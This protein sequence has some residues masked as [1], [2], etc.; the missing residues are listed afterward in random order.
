MVAKTSPT[1]RRSCCEAGDRMVRGPAPRLRYPSPATYPSAGCRAL[2]SASTSEP[3]GENAGTW[4][5]NDALLGVDGPRL[6]TGDRG[7]ARR[8]QQRECTRRPVL[9]QARLRS[10]EAQGWWLG[11]N[12]LDGALL[13]P[14]SI[15]R[16]VSCTHGAPA[17]P[18]RHG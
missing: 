1:I 10:L 11:Q 14:A 9:V 13:S 2:S 15:A 18:T 7:H 4:R 12:H 6:A 3:V 16:G 5:W 8:R 17:R